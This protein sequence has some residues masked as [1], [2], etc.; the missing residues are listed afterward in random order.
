MKQ[1]GRLEGGKEPKNKE[2]ILYKFVS[3]EAKLEQKNS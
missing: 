1:L 3:P 2:N